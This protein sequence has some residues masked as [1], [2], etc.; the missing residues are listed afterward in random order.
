MVRLI[1]SA[2]GGLHGLFNAHEHTY[3]VIGSQFIRECVAS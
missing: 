3:H 2:L 1:G